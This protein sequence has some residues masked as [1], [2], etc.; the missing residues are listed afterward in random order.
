VGA[1]HVE[2]TRR[3]QV[4]ATMH[5]CY[6]RLSRNSL[7]TIH[8]RPVVLGAFYRVMVSWIPGIHLYAVV[9]CSLHCVEL[10][11]CRLHNI[12]SQSR[13]HF[14]LVTDK[15]VFLVTSQ[16]EASQLVIPHRNCRC[17]LGCFASLL[18]WQGG[19]SPSPSPG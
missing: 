6:D 5:A 12:S 2:L 8:P 1:L 15:F 10:I 13:Y 11:I 14:E 9:S 16:C 4:V 7:C 18:V 17:V 3:Y 19:A